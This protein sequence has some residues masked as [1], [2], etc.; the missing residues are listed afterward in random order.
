MNVYLKTTFNISYTHLSS[1]QIAGMIS[2]VISS[3]V[4]G[5]L[6][7]R[8][9][10]RTFGLAM[11][12]MI[13]LFSVVW[14]FLD[15]NSTALFP[16]L[17]RVPQPVILPCCSSLLAGGIFAAV[18]LLQLNLLSALSPKEGTTMAMAVH[19]MLTGTL[20]ALGPLAGG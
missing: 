18:G 8:V 15:G 7:K 4:G 9:S 5:H 13:P 6:I 3:F 17:G 14:F 2:R 11:V 12:V 10:L 19:W 16:I 20:S 1:V